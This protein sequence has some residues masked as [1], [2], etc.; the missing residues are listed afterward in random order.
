MINCDTWCPFGRSTGCFTW[1]SKVEF[2]RRPPT[3]SSPFGSKKGSNRSRSELFTAF[4]SPAEDSA[5]I[6]AVKTSFWTALTMT[7]LACS[8]SAADGGGRGLAAFFGCSWFLFLNSFITRISLAIARFMDDQLERRLNLL[9]PSSW[10]ECD[11]VTQAT[12][13]RF[14]S[15]SLSSRRISW[16]TVWGWGSGFHRSSGP[17]V[18][19]NS[20]T[21]LQ[22]CSGLRDR[23]DCLR[24][25]CISTDLVPWRY[26]S[27]ERGLRRTRRIFYFRFE[28]SRVQPS[29]WSNKSLRWF[30]HRAL[31]VPFSRPG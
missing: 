27:F 1:Y 2:L 7:R 11:F 12:T 5:F 25:L 29:S 30:R 31:C 8:S 26:E 24:C 16:L 22:A 19:L 23:Q 20:I 10:D 14:T 4:C 17:E 21:C 15:G 3:R 9:Q 28:C 6:S 13:S 18:H